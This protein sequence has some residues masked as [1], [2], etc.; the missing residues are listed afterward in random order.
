MLVNAAGDVEILK[1]SFTMGFDVVVNVDTAVTSM[2]D[3]EIVVALV[4]GI[5]LEEV[6]VFV[7]LLG[8]DKEEV[9]GIDPTE[10]L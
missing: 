8:D 5:V 4:D 1:D 6:V 7:E 3:L 10:V 2:L 9:V